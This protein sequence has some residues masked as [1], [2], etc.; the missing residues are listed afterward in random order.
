MKLL[1]KQVSPVFSKE[2]NRVSNGVPLALVHA[3]RSNDK[4]VNVCHVT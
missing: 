1:Y 4:I 3:C 2:S